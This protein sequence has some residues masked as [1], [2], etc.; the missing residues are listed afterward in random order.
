MQM[1]DGWDPEQHGIRFPPL[2]NYDDAGDRTR[3][4]KCN[5]KD[6]LSGL[7]FPERISGGSA[8][9][10]HTKPG[11]F[12]VQLD[13]VL[14]QT[15]VRRVDGFLAAHAGCLDLIYA[16]RSGCKLDP[17]LIDTHAQHFLTTFGGPPGGTLP[18]RKNPRRHHSFARI[19]SLITEKSVG[20]ALA[21]LPMGKASGTDNIPAELLSLGGKA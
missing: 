13:A 10:A 14:V 7:G 19:T 6:A 3:Q 21:A 15:L 17:E 18:P 16:S 11:G 9:T 2:R 8:W 4:D 1:I 5:A 20:K 12:A